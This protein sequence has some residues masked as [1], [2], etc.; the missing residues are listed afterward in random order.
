MRRLFIEA[1]AFTN[2]IASEGQETLITIQDELLARLESGPVI[3]G[4]GGIRKLRIPNS[5]QGNGKRGGY[6]VIYFDVPELKRTYLLGLYGKG[7]KA[8]L[9]HKEITA[10]KRLVDR[11]KQEVR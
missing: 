1:S 8:D 10:L 4:T 9:S 2:Q 5:R 6:R 3:P 7:E 11:V